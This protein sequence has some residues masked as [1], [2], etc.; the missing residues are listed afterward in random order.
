MNV[1]LHCKVCCKCYKHRKCEKIESGA[2]IEDYMC[3]KCHKEKEAEM[4]GNFE[5]PVTRD[6]EDK[7]AG[8]GDISY[9]RDR[10]KYG[11]F[12]AARAGSCLARQGAAAYV[13]DVAREASRRLP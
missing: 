10:Q 12:L 6:V 13:C 4:E 9:S 3:K 8:D 11:S 2:P 7:S 5:V 1:G